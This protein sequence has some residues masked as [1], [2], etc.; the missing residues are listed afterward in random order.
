MKKRLEISRCADGTLMLAG[1]SVSLPQLLL[2]AARRVRVGTIVEVSGQR[3]QRIDAR[4]FRNRWGALA[5][6]LSLLEEAKDADG[7]S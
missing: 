2:R 4:R 7:R 6:Q 3:L 5:T 1:E